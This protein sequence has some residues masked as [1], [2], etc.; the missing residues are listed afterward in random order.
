METKEIL[1]TGG[2]G[3]IGS[4]LAAAL[5]EK[6]ARSIVLVDN[7]V[8]TTRQVLYNLQ[9][10][11]P[12]TVFSFYRVDIRDRLALEEVFKSHTI[13]TVVHMAALKAVGESF[14]RPYD[15]YDVNVGGT[16][17]LMEVMEAYGCRHIL[18]SSSATVYGTAPSPLTDTSPTGV[19]ITNPYGQTKWMIEQILKD[20]VCADGRW[21]AQ[22]LRYFNPIGAHPSGLLG[23]NPVKP[24]NLFPYMLRAAAGLSDGPLTVFGTDYPTADG[25]CVRDYIDISDLVEAHIAS[26]R[27]LEHA[28]V[29]P[30]EVYNIGTGVGVSVKEC[31]TVFEQATGI[32]VPHVFGPRRRG[33]LPFVIATVSKKTEEVLGWKARVP[34][35]VSCQRAWAYMEAQREAETRL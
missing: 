6:G 14:T 1:I 13:G 12:A 18:F 32:S 24:N 4:H 7:L 5:A 23:E 10:L 9:I 2:L 8:N 19:G 28:D 25:T 21:R 11:Y 34:L 16:L 22:V 29:G 27:R 3:Y 30:W 26:L 20:Q 35:E 31:L 17:S 15:Y 33:D